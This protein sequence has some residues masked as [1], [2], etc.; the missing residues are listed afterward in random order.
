[1]SGRVVADSW[2]ADGAR[3]WTRLEDVVPARW[4]SLVARAS[5]ARGLALAL[6]ARRSAVVVT[7]NP[8]PGASVAIA[9]LGLLGLRRLVLLEYIVH[10]PPWRRPVHRL[11]FVLLRQVLLRRCLLWAQV[12][13]R[14]E[15]DAYA[16]A[17]GLPVDRFR[18]VPWPGRF[19]DAPVAAVGTGRRV[20]ASGRR[21]DWTTFFAAAEGADWDVHVVC[22][23]A[24]LSEVERLGAGGGAVVRHDVSANEHQREVAAATVY[25]VPLP[26]TGASIGQIR[27]M[28]AAQAGVPVVASA[29]LGLADYVDDDCAV[30]VPPGNARALRAAVD[31]LLDDP[32]RRQRLRDTAR[33]R[34]TTMQRYR[35]ELVELVAAGPA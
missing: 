28:N 20:L 25:V 3:G 24:D 5:W 14:A 16:A 8:S 9:L 11:H 33:R 19:D 18:F 30:L 23:G 12:L 13:S 15:V 34:G 2:Y 4:R 29:V 6:A 7:T 17:H 21:T 26:E 1:V 22:S 32:A 27:I 35:D 31:A 10:P